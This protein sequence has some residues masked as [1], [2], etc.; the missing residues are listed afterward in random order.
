LLPYIV[1]LIVIPLN[2]IFKI[3]EYGSHEHTGSLGLLVDLVVET[4]RDSSNDLPPCLKI[5]AH[6][7][8]LEILLDYSGDL[9]QLVVPHHNP[10]E[11]PKEL[12]NIVLAH[13]TLESRFCGC[14]MMVKGLV[15][16]NKPFAYLART[17]KTLGM[18]LA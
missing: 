15:W 14:A 13:P 8:S 4:I 5:H 1:E 11:K 6:S 3:D 10:H 2:W 7:P 17:L 18:M 9:R 16:N 12:E